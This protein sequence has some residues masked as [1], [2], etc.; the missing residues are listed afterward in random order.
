MSHAD[1]TFVAWQLHRNAVALVREPLRLYDAEMC[2]P[3]EQTLAFGPSGVAL[4]ALGLP[5]AW[6]ASD[7][8]VTVNFVL[9]SLLLL[10][11]LAMYWAILEW[12]GEPGAALA[13]A[14][15]YAFHFHRTSDVVHLYVRDSMWTLVALVFAHR[16]FTAPRW[17]DAAGLALAGTMLLGGSLYPMFAAALLA[18]IYAGWLLWRYGTAL[19]RPAQLAA[20]AFVIGL[21]VV[22]LLGPY[23]ALDER[24]DLGT[25][26]LQIFLPTYLMSPGRSG[27]PGYL[28]VLLILAAIALPAARAMAGSVHGAVAPRLPANPRWPL[29][30]SIL[31]L[32]S[33]SLVVVPEAPENVVILS[34]EGPRPSSAMNLFLLLEGWIPGLDAGRGPGAIYF[35]AHMLLAILAGLGAAALLR[36]LPPRVRTAVAIGIVALAFVETTRPAWLGLEPRVDYESTR[37]RPDDASLRVY[38][39]LAA[40]SPDGAMLEIPAHDLH[41]TQVSQAILA[42]AYHGRPT[43]H[44]YSPYLP[45]I[46]HEVRQQAD[47]LPDADALARLYAL[48]FR[49]LVVHIPETGPFGAHRQAVFD[50]YVAG[51]GRESLAPVD[52]DAHMAGYRILPPTTST[53]A[54]HSDT[55]L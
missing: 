41:V 20:V 31:L 46:V 12:T 5:A 53:H 35:T 27:F 50:R 43:S 13:A 6:L 29:L 3:A 4:G 22:W 30:A 55:A 48:G 23:L 38:A 44:C 34:R 24:G 25:A 37:L 18:P 45:D 33:L 42:T 10:S 7:P 28:A 15:L 26:H 36:S 47:R 9:V 14:I 32:A 51:P 19:A 8:V 39:A 11:A 40:A 16:L 21:G 1:L 17:R 52:R 2:F 49:S 54:A